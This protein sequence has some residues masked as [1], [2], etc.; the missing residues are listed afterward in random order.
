MNR[1][2]GIPSP[3]LSIARSLR[4]VL[5][6]LWAAMMF[7][8]GPALADVSLRVEARPVGA[9]INAFVTVSDDLGDPVT[10]L[11]A[12]AFT[13]LVDGTP[14]PANEITFSLPPEVSEQKVSVVFAMDYSGSVQTA[15]LEAMQQAVTTFINSMEVGDYAAIVKFNNS[16]DAAVVQP[17]TAIDGPAGAGTTALISAVMA[18]YPGQGTNLFDALVLSVGQFT[19]PDVTLPAGPKA[20]VAISDGGDNVSDADLNAALAAA[21]EAK[22]SIFTVGVGNV[23]SLGTQY[24]TQLAEQ[25][26]GE[27]YLAPT[28]QEIA[29]AYLQVSELLNNEYLLSFASDITDC[30]PHEIEVSVAGQATP[31]TATFT[32]CT[33]VFAPDLQGL[34]V[35][36]ATTALTNLGLVLGTVTQQASMTV[37][38]GRVISQSPTVGTQVVEGSAVNVVVSS[39]PPPTTVPNVVGMTQAAATT[40]ITGA[41]LVV[42]TVTQQSSAT[43][44]A[45]SVISQSPAGGATVTSGS[46]VNLVVSTGPAPTVPNVVGMTQAAATTAI[47]GAGLVVGSV[48]QQ[49][50]ATVPAGSVISQ[51]PAGGTTV[52]SGSS[53]SLVISTGPAPTVPNLVGMTQSAAQ[54]AITG[55]GLVLGTVTQQSSSTVASGVVISQTP[56]SGTQVAAGASVNLVVSSGPPPAKK[57]GGGGASGPLEILAGLGLLALAARRRRWAQ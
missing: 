57:G 33:P 5:L 50:S 13:V 32:R 31:A 42:G 29:D 47:T 7:A 9:P 34:T 54:S 56:S 48:T 4:W 41:S 19:A 21:N 40:A 14:V 23:S 45:G 43:V 52:A 36:Q 46:S 25:T 3:R 18:P 6:S 15:A 1:S 2:E 22:V 44:A 12:D 30:D 51:N 10:G 55:A 27:Y 11:T 8:A 49:S 38:V 37:P 26:S 35:D 39:G 20:I 17:F 24:L 28:D 53:V 16:S